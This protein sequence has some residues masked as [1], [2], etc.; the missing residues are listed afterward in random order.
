[1]TDYLAR[2]IARAP[3][4]TGASRTGKTPETGF[5]GFGGSRATH[6][7][8]HEPSFEGFEGSRA[9]QFETELLGFRAS[10]LP[11]LPAPVTLAV[12][13]VQPPLRVSIGTH[14]RCLPVLFDSREWLA[15]VAAVE[16]DR[17]WPTHFVEWT[18]R[19]RQRP[20]W[21]LTPAEAMGCGIYDAKPGHWSVERVLQRLEL[22]LEAVTMPDDAP[23]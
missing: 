20:T 18:K 16:N 3:F 14:P 1:M 9:T 13:A 15:M 12:A 7:E 17:G 23:T 11:E 6:S 5:G 4:E 10:W 2:L 19:K 22:V 8:T 21:R